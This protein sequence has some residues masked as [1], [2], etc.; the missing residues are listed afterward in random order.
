MSSERRYS[1]EE[2]AQIL[3]HATEA[4][5]SNRPSDPR[6]TGLT[7]AELKDIGRDVGI[8]PDLIGQ[9]ASR[10]AAHDLVS[11]PHRQFLGTTIGV[12]RTVDLHRP[13]NG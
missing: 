10:I 6:G 7:L 9:A 8:S 5:K 1:E 3:D 12:G 11:P 2:I 13:L 4:Q